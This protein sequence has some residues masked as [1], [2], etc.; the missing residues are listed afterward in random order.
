MRGVSAASSCSTRGLEPGGLVGLHDH[1]HAAGQRDG[2][3]I[4]GPV[5]GR[6]DDLVARVAQRGERGEHRVLAAVGDQHLAGLT[7]EPGVAQRLRGD[8][9]AQLGQAGGRGV[10]VELR[11][12]AGARGGLDDVLR[13]SGS[14]VRRHRSRSRS[15]PWPSA[16]WPWRRRR[17]WPIRRW[18]RDVRTCGSLRGPSTEFRRRSYWGPCR[19]PGRHFVK[20]RWPVVLGG[21]D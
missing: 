14:R 6:T 11:V 13:A 10:L 20:L 12:A 21:R 1:R 17:A 5:R 2:L 3:G 8:R 9:L 19:G 15:R 7:G 16:P 4:G 18:R